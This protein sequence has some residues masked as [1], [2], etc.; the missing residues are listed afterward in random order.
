MTSWVD[1]QFDARPMV[2]NHFGRPRITIGSLLIYSQHRIWQSDCYGLI[3]L[4]MCQWGIRICVVY[5]FRSRITN[6][7]L[8]I[9][10]DTHIVNCFRLNLL[11]WYSSLQIHHL[12]FHPACS[13]ILGEICSWIDFLPTYS[14]LCDYTPQ[15]L[16]VL[17]HFFSPIYM[18]LLRAPGIWKRVLVMVTEIRRLREH[19][20]TFNRLV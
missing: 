5:A 15:Y 14:K 6:S 11:F 13:V 10:S 2:E 16:Y 19:S 8:T 1:M 7:R 17:L 12:I 9:K 4:F 18:K 20:S 3:Y